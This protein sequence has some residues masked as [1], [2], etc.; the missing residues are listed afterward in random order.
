MVISYTC[1]RITA[2]V[3]ITQ[4]MFRPPVSSPTLCAVLLKSQSA[5]KG[6]VRCT[7]LIPELSLGSESQYLHDPDKPDGHLLPTPLLTVTQGPKNK[8][9]VS[10]ER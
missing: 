8:R 3:R 10:E 6:E 4:G 2:Y 7:L 5:R 1:V 9:G